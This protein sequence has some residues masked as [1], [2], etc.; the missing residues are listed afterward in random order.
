MHLVGYCDFQVATLCK[1]DQSLNLDFLWLI[2]KVSQNVK[3]W[4]ELST[5]DFMW[6]LNHSQAPPL[7]LSGF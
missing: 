7:L 2:S 3:L 5:C 1:F 6:L 4:L